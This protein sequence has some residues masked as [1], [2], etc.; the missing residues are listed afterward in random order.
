MSVANVLDLGVYLGLGSAIDVERAALVL[1]L[2]EARCSAIL[3]PLP[4]EAKGIVL[5][6]AQRAYTN[7]TGAQ[8]QSVGQFS[9]SMPSIGVSL[10]AANRRELRQLGGRGGAFSIDPTPADAG[11]RLPVW[12]QNVTFLNGTPGLDDVGVDQ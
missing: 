6:V 3:S 7:A 5:D 1:E 12:D 4:D 8:S 9:M 2:A 11:T 10:T